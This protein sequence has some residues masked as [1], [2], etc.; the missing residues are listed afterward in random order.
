M[1]ILVIEDEQKVAH[2]IKR[3]L[4]Q[5]SHVVDVVFDGRKGLSFALYKEYD[6]I[7]L[8]LMLPGMDGREICR[9]LRKG[10]FATPILMLTAKAQTTDK[11]AG[12]NDGADD[13]LAKP[14]AFDE[15]LARIHALGRRPKPAFGSVLEC[16]NLR[17]DTLARTVVRGN[18]AIEL[19]VKEYMLLEY[20]L[21]N[22]GMVVSKDQIMAHVWDRDADILP[23]TV[24]VYIGYLR[25]KIDRASFGPPLIQTVRGFGYRLSAAEGMQE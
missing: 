1:K 6:V 3:G 11:V 15:L 2:A 21:R 16:G 19:S 4:E 13:Y 7:V 10:K 17:C 24:E 14:F 9:E 5:E 25:N 18:T 20:L 12:L 22:A 23:N 8:D